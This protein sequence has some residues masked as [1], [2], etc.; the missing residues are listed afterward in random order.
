MVIG[1]D[2]TGSCKSN[3]HTITT[4]TAPSFIG[5]LSSLYRSSYSF[6]K[7]FKYDLD[8]LLLFIFS[9]VT[10]I[11]EHPI[12]GPEE[13][14]CW[15]FFVCL[16]ITNVCTH[17]WYILNG[18]FSKT[19]PAWVFTCGDYHVAITVWN[20]VESYVK[21]RHPINPPLMLE[22]ETLFWFFCLRNF[23]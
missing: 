8:T 12:L 2:C 10:V 17:Y 22:E 18:N 7:T 20:I 6:C 3:Y 21:H 19:L 13:T 16:F 11:L 5:D 15:V 1:T 9:L 14:F 23:I 4:T